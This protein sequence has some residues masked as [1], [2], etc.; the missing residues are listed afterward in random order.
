MAKKNSHGVLQTGG[1]VMM[2]NGDQNHSSIH[3]QGTMADNGSVIIGDDLP[4]L[5][6]VTNGNGGTL[7]VTNDGGG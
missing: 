3:A 2:E 5:K 7:I 6:E 1:E 4:S